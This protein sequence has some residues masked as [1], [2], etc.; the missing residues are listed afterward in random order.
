M[1]IRYIEQSKIFV[2]ETQNT[3]YCIGALYDEG[4]LTHLYYGD[5]LE[6]SDASYLLKLVDQYG[7]PSSVMRDRSFFST[8][9]H[10]NILQIMLEITGKVA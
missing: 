2:I 1:D 8:D 4:F 5:K 3:S 10:L 9:S 7:T 6:I